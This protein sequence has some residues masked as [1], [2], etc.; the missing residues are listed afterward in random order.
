MKSSVVQQ[1]LGIEAVNPLKR[2]KAQQH[3]LKSSGASFPPSY[4]MNDSTL[5]GG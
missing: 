5:I 4:A 2:F 1:F 3:T